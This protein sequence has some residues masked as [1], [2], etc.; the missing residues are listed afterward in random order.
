MKKVLMFLNPA[1]RQGAKHIDE[2]VAWLNTNQFELLNPGY[3]PANEDM[4]EVIE[5][6][7]TEA[8][9][10]LIG[11]GDG[12]VNHALP[13]LISTKLPLLL[14]PLGTANNLARTL[15]IPTTVPDA[16]MLLTSAHTKLVDVGMVSQ[17]SRKG[18][19]LASIP[20]V[21]V[22]GI[23]M[24]AKVNRFVPSEQKRWLGVFAFALTA[25]RVASRMSPFRVEIETD[26][27]KHRGRSWQVTVCNGRNYG[28]GLVID[29][30]ATLTDQTLHGITTEIGKWWHGFG[31]IPA[32]RAGRFESTRQVK[33]FSGNVIKISTR[34]SKHVD[35]DGDLK[36]R[37]PI[38]I[39]VYVSALKIFVPETNE[40][41]TT[42]EN[43]EA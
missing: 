24:S 12:S 37:T 18:E 21:N 15:A 32:L 5:K 22:I 17:I 9:A 19:A 31:L 25:I 4:L 2:I 8:D 7:K 38:E 41:R 33:S 43:H 39:S 27:R 34:R 1:S 16:L 10:V 30:A 6:C 35:I 11:G 26:G 23:G 40:P 29:H 20:F 36:A 3:D 14:I 13:A 42:S 28:N